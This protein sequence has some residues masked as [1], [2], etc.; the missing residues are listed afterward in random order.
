M[1]IYRTFPLVAPALQCPEEQGTAKLL[2]WE[3]FCVLIAPGL[4]LLAPNP[5]FPACAGTQLRVGRVEDRAAVD[6]ANSAAENPH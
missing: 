2:L 5:P 1:R 4:P 3:L 6:R